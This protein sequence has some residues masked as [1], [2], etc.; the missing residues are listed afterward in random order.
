MK[1]E[2]GFPCYLA[3]TR[4]KLE[5]LWRDTSLVAK[6]CENYIKMVYN[7]KYYKSYLTERARRLILGKVI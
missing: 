5:I 1:E 3:L 4:L 7:R 6:V 2:S